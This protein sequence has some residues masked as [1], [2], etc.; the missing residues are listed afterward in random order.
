MSLLFG[1]RFK[2]E[3]YL[4]QEEIE[5]WLKNGLL[6]NAFEAF[7][8]D[9]AHK[10]YVQH[11]MQEHLEL[12]ND[13]LY[14]R[15]GFFYLCGIGGPLETSVRQEVKNAFKTCN[16]WD[17]ETADKYIEQFTKEGRYNFETW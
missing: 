6:D 7:S 16:K 17:E 9:Q 5:D 2:K 11:R 15:K 1:S 12:I 14:T 4:Y 13:Y 8:R 10:I 3:D